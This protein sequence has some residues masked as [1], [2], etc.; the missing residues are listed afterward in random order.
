MPIGGLNTKRE[1]A[2]PAQPTKRIHIASA[3]ELP[4]TNTIAR[5]RQSAS[6]LQSQT[7]HED[8]RH[9]RNL[10][11]G[12]SGSAFDMTMMMDRP[13]VFDF[14]T[15]PYDDMAQSQQQADTFPDLPARAGSPRD[16]GHG[17]LV[18][19]KSGASSKY[20]G[21]TAASEWLKDVCGAAKDPSR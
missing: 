15:S 5:Q 14:N 11:A 13:L 12:A 6:A 4:I 20:Y 10:T 18:M 8:I 19:S 2:E 17:T 3:A 9:G 1:D 21:H 16:L 7:S